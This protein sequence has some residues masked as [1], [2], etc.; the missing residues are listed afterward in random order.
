MK[1]RKWFI[2]CKEANVK[3]VATGTVVVGGSYLAYRVVRV[4]PS[5]TPPLWW[6]IPGKLAIP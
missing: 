5:L 3:K 6:T 2:K 4:I 1:I